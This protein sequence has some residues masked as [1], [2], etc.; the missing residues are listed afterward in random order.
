[1]VIDRETGDIYFV[2]ICRLMPSE[3]DEKL[4]ELTQ[5]ITYA[6]FEYQKWLKFSVAVHQRLE[7]R[8]LGALLAEI[9]ELA[10]RAARTGRLEEYV[11]QGVVTAAVADYHDPALI[12][13]A[14]RHNMEV[15]AYYGPNE[16][17]FRRAVNKIWD[18]G[19]QA[20]EHFPTLL[21]IKV[22]DLSMFEATLDEWIEAIDRQL[23][24][25]PS[26]AGILLSMHQFGNGKH[27]L[28]VAENVLLIG[29]D[30]GY[31]W[32]SQSILIFNKYSTCSGIL[33][34]R[35]R[36]LLKDFL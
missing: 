3:L 22:E 5:R 20:T 34:E 27:W 31:T 1:M 29:R 17:P 25:C 9:V 36:H 10:R 4:T 2:E 26:V 33:K 8:A 16:P 14:E 13:W 35:H 7:K 19:D 12:D 6:G 30:E 15:N 21:V 18:K 24:R 23:Q 28:S 11:V 32:R